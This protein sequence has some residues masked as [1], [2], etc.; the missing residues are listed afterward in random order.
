MK[1]LLAL[2]ILAIS[3]TAAE[4]DLREQLADALY[5]EEVERDPAAAADAYQKILG[6]FDA[7]RPLAAS[8]LFRL[9]EIRRQQQHKDQAIALYQRL[10]REF[11]EF[12]REA[13]LARQHLATL[14][15]EAPA[16]G[17][18]ATDSDQV[19]LLRLKELARTSPDLLLD[20]ETLNTAIASGYLRTIEYLLTEIKNPGDEDCLSTAVGTANVPIC[21]ALLHYRKPT[22]TEAGGAL[23]VA[24][25]LKHFTILELLLDFGLD[26]NSPVPATNGLT[27]SPLITAVVKGDSKALT[28]LLKKGANIDFMIQ[29]GAA[30]FIS[31]P[32]GSALHTAVYHDD[33]KL[34]RLLL[35]NGAEPDL[36]TPEAGITPLHLAVAESKGEA[37]EILKLLLEQKINVNRRT[38]LDMETPHHSAKSFIRSTPFEIALNQEQDDA[39]RLLI[40]AGAKLSPDDRSGVDDLF[41]AIADGRWSQV[42]L[43]LRVGLNPNVMN[44]YGFTALYRAIETQSPEG[45][46]ILLEA[47]ANPNLDNPQSPAPIIYA[48]AS[49]HLGSTRALLEGGKVEGLQKALQFAIQA[50]KVEVVELLLDA[51]ADPNGLDSESLPPLAHVLTPEHKALFDLLLEKGADPKLPFGKVAFILGQ[52]SDD[53]FTGTEADPFADS[54]EP[55]IETTNS[56]LFIASAKPETLP[57]FETLL[58]AGAVPGA[59]LGFII[60]NIAPHDQDGSIV[61]K[62]LEFRPD[63][64]D[65]RFIPPMSRWTPA[66]R[67]VFL[68]SAVY[69][70]FAAKP[71]IQFL[72]LH[73]GQAMTLAQKSP[74]QPSLLELL[75]AHRNF[76]LKPENRTGNPS[77]YASQ[78]ALVRKQPSGK[79]GK[80]PIDLSGDAP[81]PAL[82]WGDIITAEADIPGPEGSAV[83]ALFYKRFDWGIHR[84][85]S[86]P[87]TVTVD[88]KTRQLTLNGNLLTIDPASDQLPILSAGDLA[89]YLWQAPYPLESLLGPELIVERDG[90]GRIQLAPDDNGSR[91]F[92]L[93]PGDHLHL[94]APDGFEELMEQQRPNFV[95]LTIPGTPFSRHFGPVKNY[96]ESPQN[97]ATLPTLTQAITD[98]FAPTLDFQLTDP[99]EISNLARDRRIRL[100]ELPP[101]PDFAKIRI[102]RLLPDGTEK[103]IDVNLA[104]AIAACTPNT[105]ATDLRASDIRLQ[106]G[107]VV[108]LSLPPGGSSTGQGFS[109]SEQNYLG[110]IHSGSIRFF[111]TGRPPEKFDFHWHAAEWIDTEAGRIPFISPKGSTSN[112]ASRLSRLAPWPSHA[113]LSI[114]RDGVKFPSEAGDQ[115]FLMDGDSVFINS[116]SRRGRSPRPPS[117]TPRVRRVPKG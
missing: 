28:L 38:T 104:A 117:N 66:A 79:W 109:E 74:S 107:D 1:A 60:N 92:E 34:V 81:L 57:A 103:I 11:P 88:G 13:E 4:P 22:P 83:R 20:P 25:R 54:D 106:A 77:I 115:L 65:T 14:G 49:G 15:G 19:E 59:G 85:T 96:A 9:A 29:S 113:N 94:S 24:I 5:T 97:P 41:E 17:S 62:L 80:Q 112:R 42:K 30:R 116:V 10:L 82:Q 93:Q 47:G 91:L 3:L 32:L 16:P 99:A 21:L 27:S 95:R 53:P 7:K 90:W 46:R 51:G 55:R 45:I 6:D 102:R 48:I 23:A 63:H 86:F 64:F 100:P 52:G 70:A 12:E 72:F 87:I 35:E 2:L 98:A 36:P 101:H 105:S 76:I 31:V 110:K 58:A 26:P 33:A 111:A 61:A 75:K 18:P 40:E 67:K 50:N 108:E 39:A 56:L 43:L 68:E 73:S 44:K 71:G 37:T 78:L 69:P 8:A 114:E 89:S 84:R